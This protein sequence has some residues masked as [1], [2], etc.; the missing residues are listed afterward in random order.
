MPMVKITRQCRD[1]DA[2]RRHL[3]P[4][5]STIEPGLVAPES[6]CPIGMRQMLPEHPA[7]NR[8]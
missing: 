5:L 4:G 7:P 2:R 6:V 3:A 8:H 1:F